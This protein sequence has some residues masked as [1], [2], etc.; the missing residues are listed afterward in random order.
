MLDSCKSR[1]TF[2]FRDAE[3]L[4]KCDGAVD[5]FTVL[6]GGYLKW[7]SLIINCKL[8]NPGWSECFLGTKR[9]LGPGA[10]ASG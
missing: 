5:G 8:H 2:L 9:Y 4:G 7:G 1:G 10:V 6:S 3:Q